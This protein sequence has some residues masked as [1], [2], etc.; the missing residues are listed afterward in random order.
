[1][2]NN[3]L[4]IGSIITLLIVVSG[5]CAG[6]FYNHSR[7]MAP[8]ASTQTIAVEHRINPNLY[9]VSPPSRGGAILEKRSIDIKPHN[10]IAITPLPPKDAKGIE[11][12]QKVL[13]YDANGVL[14]QILGEITAVTPVSKFVNIGMVLNNDAQHPSSVV[15]RGEIITKRTNDAQ[16][17][18]LTAIVKNDAGEDHVWEVTKDNDG[19]SQAFYKPANVIA[20]TYDFAVIEQQDSKSNLFILNPDNSL[21]DGQQVNAR[22]ILYSGPEQTDDS[23]IARLVEQRTPLSPTDP[24]KGPVVTAPCGFAAN[25][26]TEQQSDQSA[27]GQQ[28]SSSPDALQDFITKIRQNAAPAP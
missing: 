16:R 25:T 8:K 20:R 22:P 24:Y 10:N 4:L 17:L 12:G 21:M 11:P 28:G 19:M 2:K 27:C 6:Y 1:M 13:L 7:K 26:E 18:P 5:V 14:L 23:K 15:T 3:R 9:D